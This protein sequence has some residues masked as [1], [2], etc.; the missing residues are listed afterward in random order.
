MW[1]DGK[2]QGRMSGF[3]EKKV[4]LLSATHKVAGIANP[5]ALTNPKHFQMKSNNL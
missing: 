5:G 3:T 2:N 1:K 4:L